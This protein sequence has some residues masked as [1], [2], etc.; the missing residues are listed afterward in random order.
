[1]TEQSSLGRATLK[2]LVVAISA[3]LA[4][5]WLAVTVF[6]IPAEFPPLAGPAPTIFFTAIGTLGAAG[7]LGIVRRRAAHPGAAFRR[8]AL[9]ALMVSFVPDFWLFSGSASGVFPGATSTGVGVLMVLHMVAA[10][11]IVWGLTGL[12]FSSTAF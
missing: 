6:D 12:R 4:V 9:L 8:I 5:R 11:T 7:V 10:L 2:A 3:T 1:M